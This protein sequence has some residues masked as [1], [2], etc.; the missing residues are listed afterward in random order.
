MILFIIILYIPGAD[1]EDHAKNKNINA[2]EK[3]QN[4]IL[5]YYNDI[6]NNSMA[7]SHLR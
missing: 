2:K 1:A 7:S 4:D 3:K 5:N 6:A